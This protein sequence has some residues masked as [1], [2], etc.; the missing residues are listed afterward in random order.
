MNVRQGRSTTVPP[1]FLLPPPFSL[2]PPAAARKGTLGAESSCAWV[3]CVASVTQH[4]RDEH[5]ETQRMKVVVGMSIGSQR[6]VCEE[7]EEEEKSYEH[8]EE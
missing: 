7:V 1:S 5:T 6:N 4:E 8:E 2:P 3:K